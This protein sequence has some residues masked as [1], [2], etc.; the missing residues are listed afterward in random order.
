MKERYI[1]TAVIPVAGLGT[2][3]GPFTG[4]EPKF[5]AGI[6]EGNRYRP[7]IDYTLD[8]CIGA[9][10]ENFIFV[11]SNGGDKHLQRYLGPL[12]VDVRAQYKKLGKIKELEAEE[13]R[14]EVFADLNITYVEQG[15]DDPY[16]TAVPLNLARAALR[17]VDY[18]AVTGGDDFVWNAG[19]T[20]ELSLAIANWQSS[21]ADH[22]IMG[23]PISLREEAT[24]YGIL[25]TD[26]DGLLLHID[27]KPPLE[28][29]PAKPLANISRYILNGELIW[30]HVDAV[31]A[32][33]KDTE[34]PEYYVT[35][36]INSALLDNQTFYTHP[37]QGMYF[38]A[39]SPQ[40]ILDAS[41]HITLEIL[42]LQN[43][44]I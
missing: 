36:V 30:P 23:K 10:I 22:A 5:M 7:N 39:G 43:L 15:T 9:G 29:I 26:E 37:V 21:G 19:R 16:G 41:I 11:V 14:R 38:D 28:R 18:F 42:K 2:R 20:S 17:G 8:D 4:G 35:D 1:D 24:K 25:Q 33:Q 27:E 3:M 6:S 32:Q 40:G 13:A 12:N 34:Q 31:L 44:K